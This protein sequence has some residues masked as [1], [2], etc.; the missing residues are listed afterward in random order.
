MIDQVHIFL[1]FVEVCCCISISIQDYSLFAN[2]VFKPYSVLH[3]CFGS[4]NTL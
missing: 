1:Y 4:F 3:S 2:F